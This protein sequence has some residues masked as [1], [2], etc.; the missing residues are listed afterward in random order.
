MTAHRQA[1]TLVL[2]AALL[3]GCEGATELDFPAL[4]LERFEPPSA[5]GEWW[6]RTEACSGLEAPLARVRFFEVRAPVSR[7]G[8]RFPCGDG[9]RALECSGVWQAPH[10]IYL[11]PALVRHERLVRHEMLHDLVG[12]PGHPPVFEACGLLEPFTANRR[13]AAGQAEPGPPTGGE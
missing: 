1:R 6:A 5:Y 12:T 2:L 10:D 7:D 9:R 11:A 3:A 13:A 8:T 4:D